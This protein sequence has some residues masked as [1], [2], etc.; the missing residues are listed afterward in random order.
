MRA[1][2]NF[3]QGLVGGEVALA[4]LV[5]PCAVLR[6]TDVERRVRAIRLFVGQPA[7][8]HAVQ[9]KSSLQLLQPL[10]RLVR[11]PLGPGELRTGG[12][13]PTCSLGFV[14]L[15]RH[16]SCSMGRSRESNA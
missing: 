16:L 6:D 3:R 11:E 5:L 1:G 2:G 4:V 14:L 7:Q 13:F 12:G 10:W 8:R 9:H 15:C